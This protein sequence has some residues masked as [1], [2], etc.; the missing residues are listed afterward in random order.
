MIVRVNIVPKTW[1]GAGAV[2]K[3]L[4]FFL[5][6]LVLVGVLL[7]GCRFN[8]SLEYP[9]C[10]NPSD[11]PAPCVC[12]SGHCLPPA[13]AGPEACTTI[14]TSCQ[15][16]FDCMTFCTCK[17]GKCQPRED[18]AFSSAECDPRRIA[19]GDPL[20]PLGL[21]GFGW[22]S[23]PDRTLV[24][25]SNAD[26]VSPPAGEIT[27]RAALAKAAD[28]SQ[29]SEQPVRITF[30]PVVFSPQNQNYIHLKEPLNMTGRNI[31][32]DG[33]GS[34]VWLKPATLQDDTPFRVSCRTCLVANLKMYMLPGFGMEVLGAEDLYLMGIEI[35]N[36]GESLGRSTGGLLVAGGSRRITIGDGQGHPLIDERQGC[37]FHNNTGPGL[38][39]GDADSPPEDVTVFGMDSSGNLD[40]QTTGVG[41]G[42]AVRGKAK[43][44]SIGVPPG[45]DK[46]IR[47]NNEFYDNGQFGVSLSGEFDRV[48]VRGN[49]IV[50]QPYSVALKNVKGEVKF[51][52]NTLIDPQETVVDCS[53]ISN[54]G[55]AKFWAVN[56]IFYAENPIS[57]F[58]NS[59]AVNTCNGLD[60][61]VDYP[62]LFNVEC[63][64]AAM[65]GLCDWMNLATKFMKDPAFQDLTW[66]VPTDDEAANSAD[67]NLELGGILL[68]TNG[69]APGRFNGNGP[70]IGAIEEP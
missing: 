10:E 30:D 39:I 70:A 27:L 18:N 12:A 43:N 65:G 51:V 3:P 34:N 61:Y 60:V 36:C 48:I 41:A 35:W 14:P 66:P 31:F 25:N 56:N 28:L 6:R 62:L 13:G 24:V 15:V 4:S 49:L 16:D 57:N 58:W 50:G 46:K 2:G 64:A 45:L 38:V 23:L 26:E 47:A 69:P 21:L 68:D 67:P 42:V 29:K 33:R 1:T 7:A 5:P 59:T 19:P 32:L 37:Y 54:N 20:G 40:F 8:P 44:V 53:A 9:P 22:G 52:H 55:Q 17:D 11:C 63:N